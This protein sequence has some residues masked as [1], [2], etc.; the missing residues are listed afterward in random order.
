MNQELAASEAEVGR[1]DGLG[2]VLTEP[3]SGRARGLGCHKAEASR[4]VSISGFG[5]FFTFCRNLPV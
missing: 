4:P 3:V 5:T 2:S 1:S